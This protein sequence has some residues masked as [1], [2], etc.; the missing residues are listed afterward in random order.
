[1]WDKISP[2]FKLPMISL[3]TVLIFVVGM[4]EWRN[5]GYITAIWIAL[6]IYGIVVTRAIGV[7]LD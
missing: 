7:K 4:L 6:W 2:L 1:M 5:L 3:I